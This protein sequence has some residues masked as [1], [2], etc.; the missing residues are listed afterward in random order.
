MGL[1][2]T[3]ICQAAKDVRASQDTL[4]DIF[5]RVQMFF[6]RLE[7]YT[8][9]PPTKEM[10]D[11]IVLIMVEVLSILGVATEEIKQSRMSKKFVTS[12]SPALTE[13]C[14]EKFGKRL[15]GKRDMEDALKRLDKLTEEEVRMAVAQNLK[16]TH[17]VDERVGGVANM[18]VAM[19]NRMAGVHDRVAY[20]DNSVKGVDAGVAIV[21]CSVKMVDHKVAEVLHGA[22]IHF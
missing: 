6:R 12:V 1:Y 5:E 16:A 19:D 18:V 2:N 9:V 14:S 15:I 22:Q 17:I 7:I 8:E 4:M 21:G 13:R 20:V 10:M 3:Y 11:T